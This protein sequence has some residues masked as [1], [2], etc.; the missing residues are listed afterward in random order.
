MLQGNVW[1]L[2]KEQNLK[3]LIFLGLTWKNSSVEFLVVI[4]NVSDVI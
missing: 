3:S 4:T 1:E 2:E